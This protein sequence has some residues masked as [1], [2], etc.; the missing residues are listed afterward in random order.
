MW[1][2]LYFYWTVPTDLV[3]NCSE[4]PQEDTG[5]ITKRYK[6]NYANENKGNY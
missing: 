5:R 3:E 6:E 4:R 1:V 2:A